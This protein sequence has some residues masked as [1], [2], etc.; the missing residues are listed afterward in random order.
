M[1]EGKQQLLINFQTFMYM[2]IFLLKDY[3]NFLFLKVEKKH[4]IR[5]LSWKASRVPFPEKKLSL[6]KSQNACSREICVTSDYQF[7]V[8][9]N[10]TEPP[11]A[12]L[13]CPVYLLILN[14][15][16]TMQGLETSADKASYLSWYFPWTE[17][18]WCMLCLPAAYIVL[19]S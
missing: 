17:D 7:R 2:M 18:C 4:R 19:L 10:I 5:K 12:S 8:H 6:Q 9:H 13:Y 1:W 15:P 3:S 14:L 11:T 16:Q